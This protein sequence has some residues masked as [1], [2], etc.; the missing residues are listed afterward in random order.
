VIARLILLDCDRQTYMGLFKT[1]LRAYHED[2]SSL[3][4][5]LCAYL[6]KCLSAGLPDVRATIRVH[7]DTLRYACRAA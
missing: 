7:E 6:C 2:V 1:S 3:V 5:K 4:K